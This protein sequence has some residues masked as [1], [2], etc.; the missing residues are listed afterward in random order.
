MAAVAA[1]AAPEENLARGH[2]RCLFCLFLVPIFHCDFLAVS[3]L[4][5]VAAG[6]YWRLFSIVIFFRWFPP[7][8]R[9]P[10]VPILYSVLIIVSLPGRGSCIMPIPCEIVMK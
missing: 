5:A 9:W 1:A 6:A 10:P 3:S 4:A 2:W 7:W 8:P